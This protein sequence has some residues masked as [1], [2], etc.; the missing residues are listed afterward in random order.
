[1]DGVRFGILNIR[2]VYR[3]PGG[4]AESVK[5]PLWEAL[6]K[7]GL[8]GTDNL[9]VR[10]SDVQGPKDIGLQASVYGYGAADGSAKVPCIDMPCTLEPST[11]LS[12]DQAVERLVPLIGQAKNIIGVP[13]RR[14]QMFSSNA[15][16]QAF[17]PDLIRRQPPSRRQGQPSLMDLYKAACQR[18]GKI[19]VL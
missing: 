14:L 4:L 6:E 12:V 3:C 7:A 2:T 8:T 15:L 10:L 16:L 18:E 13:I 11:G 5:Q 19:P 17:G 9:E 1:M